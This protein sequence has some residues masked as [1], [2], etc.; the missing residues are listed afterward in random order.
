M[1]SEWFLVEK[2]AGEG[3]GVGSHFCSFT[4]DLVQK[5]LFYAI[6]DELENEA[7]KWPQSWPPI[8]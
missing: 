5:K 2:L 7:F 6:V 4:I 3:V 8:F 1:K